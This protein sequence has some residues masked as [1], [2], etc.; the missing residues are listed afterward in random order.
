MKWIKE[1]RIKSVFIV[2]LLV[3]VV[4]FLFGERQEELPYRVTGSELLTTK[5]E[6]KDLAIT[7]VA[8]YNDSRIGTHQ[9][10]GH[11]YSERGGYCYAEIL[12]NFGE[13][14]SKLLYNTTQDKEV[15]RRAWP[16]DVRWYDYD[17]DR[18]VLGKL[19]IID[20][21]APW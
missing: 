9:L 8:Y 11:G 3:L 20:F 10:M 16:D 12:Q 1:N 4:S 2:L 5:E 6:C 19:K 7:K 15:F 14:D 17:F 18:I 21:R 13:D